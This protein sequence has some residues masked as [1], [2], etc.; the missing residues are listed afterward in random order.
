M[1]QM[2]A[3]ATLSVC[4]CVRNLRAQRMKMVQTLV[5]EY[6]PRPLRVSFVYVLQAQYEFIHHALSELVVCGETEVTATSL[7]SFTE[8]L[9]EPVSDSGLTL[10]L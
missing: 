3:E 4:Q 2:K 9:R 1:Q 5:R 10:S 7:R 8:S 6:S